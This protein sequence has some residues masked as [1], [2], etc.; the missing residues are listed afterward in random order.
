[1]RSGFENFL[2]S[3]SQIDSLANATSNNNG[4]LLQKQTPVFCRKMSKPYVPVSWKTYF[5]TVKLS[6][7]TSSSLSNVTRNWGRRSKL[8]SF[9]KKIMRFFKY[10]IGIRIV[11]VLQELHIDFRVLDQNTHHDEDWG[12]QRNLVFS[13]SFS[14]F[15][16]WART[17]HRFLGF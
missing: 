4:V 6:W 15:S 7:W 5:N 14:C 10:L 1:M 8:V 16:S 11:H 2:V 17:Q 9:F 13:S 12:R 3:I